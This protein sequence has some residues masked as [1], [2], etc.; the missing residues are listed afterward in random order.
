[1]QSSYFKKTI[2]I[3][4]QKLDKK[5]Y[6]KL[7]SFKFIILLNTLSKMLK[8][9]ILKRLCYVVKAYNTL[10]DTQIRVKR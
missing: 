1:M 3:M 8:S 4:L 7:S 5:N 9:I 6:L 2:T 10:L